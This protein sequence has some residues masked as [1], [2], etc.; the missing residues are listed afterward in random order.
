[1]G[2]TWRD[3]VSSIAILAIILTW[4]AYEV[5]AGLPLLSS[6]GT[7]SVMELALGVCC[8]VTAAF[9]LH[10]T[11]QPRVGVIFRRITT[12]TGTIALVAGLI[13]TLASSG[14]ALEILVVSTA[15]LWVAATF[16]HVLGIGAE[17]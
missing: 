10:T 17:Q 2:L 14:Q 16:W 1:M 8:A 3:L 12:V 13:G 11:P 15:V 7:T 9:D 5:R 6:A 4:W